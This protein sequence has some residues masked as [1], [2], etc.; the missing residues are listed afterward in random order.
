MGHFVAENENESSFRFSKRTIQPNSS[1]ASAS[2]AS[3]LTSERDLQFAKTSI[4]FRRVIFWVYLGFFAKFYLFYCL[5]EDV[6][7]FD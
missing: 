1:S 4:S 7:N 5:I 2:L 3:N 6:N